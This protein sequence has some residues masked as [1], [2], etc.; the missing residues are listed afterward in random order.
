MPI[1]EEID[2][3]REGILSPDSVEDPELK[4]ALKAPTL[5]TEQASKILTEAQV[6]GIV[7]ESILH[8]DQK[9]ESEDDAEEKANEVLRREFTLNEIAQDIFVKGALFGV[10]ESLCHE[11]VNVEV[12]EHYGSYMRLRVERHNKS[13]GFLFRLIEE[14]KEE[15]QL[16]DYSVSQTTLE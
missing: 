13:I 5:T 12:I 10:I 2:E 3:V 1:P 15:H 16:E 11:F 9:F 4:E 7:I 8:L 14:L 6:P